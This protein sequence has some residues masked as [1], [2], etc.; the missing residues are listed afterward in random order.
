MGRPKGSKNKKTLEREGK[1]APVLRAKKTATTAA[2]SADYPLIATE[3][4]ISGLRDMVNSLTMRLDA[5]TM[6]TLQD[7]RKRLEDYLDIHNKLLVQIASKLA[8]LENTLKPEAVSLS[9][10]GN[11]NEEESHVNGQ[12]FSQEVQG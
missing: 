6:Q 10:K 3:T 7:D 12:D 4:D 9:A 1:I 2:I 8:A 5:L 11:C